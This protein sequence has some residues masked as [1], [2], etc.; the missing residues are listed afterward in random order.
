VRT[1]RLSL[2]AAL[3]G[4]MLLTANA[5][6]ADEEDGIPS[7]KSSKDRD[8]EAFATKVGTAIVKAARSK[9]ADVKLEK[10]SYSSPKEGRKDLKIKMGY[11]GSITKKQFHSDIVVKIDSGDDKKWEV[12]NIDYED[13]NK[14]SLAKPNKAKIQELIKKFNR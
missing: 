2:F 10:Y 8:T 3:A 9:P 11:K 1:L 5:T 14:T 6:R 4:L 12:L 7:F 13:D